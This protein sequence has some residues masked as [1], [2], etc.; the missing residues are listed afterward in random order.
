MKTR[1]LTIDPS[2]PDPAVIAEA[3]YVLRSGGLVAFPT[4]TVYG[5]G[6]NALDPDAVQ[7]IFIAKDRPA[8]DPLIVHI[9]E[10][11]DLASVALDLPPIADELV[12][13]CFPGA[14]T[15]IL[16]RHPRIAAN[17]SAGL[18]TVAV[19][20]PSHLVAHALIAAAG[21]PVAAPSANRFSRPSAT[22][23]RHVLQDLDGRVDMILDGGAAFIGVESTILDLTVDPPA[24]LRPGGVSLE[25]IRQIVPS[26]VVRSRF[27]NL[28]SAASA[29]GQ[30]LK[31]YSPRAELRLYI[32]S[33]Q[34]MIAQIA[35][36]AR[37]LTAAG[38]RVGVL[39]ANEDALDLPNAAILR[40]GSA[41]DLNQ[42]A[43]NLFSGMRDLDARHVDVILA[44]DFGENGLGLAIRDRL[45]RAAEGR[46]IQVG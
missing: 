37:A 38:K 31:H 26:A 12:Q 29:P 10:R 41:S 16:K 22:T 11:A 4:E 5:L 14:L 25:S 42:I 46:I 39:V 15:L 20:M 13:R 35:E 6:A 9:A 8:T 44:R 36:D 45:T 2:H 30:M 24:V 32:G 3:A 40:L 1:I 18:D 17:V 23:V 33:P 34:D 43:V 28:D 27:V 21:I 19:R 7:R